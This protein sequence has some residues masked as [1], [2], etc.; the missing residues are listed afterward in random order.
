[1]LLSRI[2]VKPLLS[3]FGPNR[4]SQAHCGLAAGGEQ[5]ELCQED[6]NSVMLCER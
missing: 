5:E 1:M 4:T 3:L 2:P 6:A